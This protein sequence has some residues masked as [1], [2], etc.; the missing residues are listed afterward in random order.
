MDDPVRYQTIS[1][2][3]R[4]QCQLHGW[5]R[6]ISD[7]IRWYQMTVSIAWMTPSDVWMSNSFTSP[8]PDPLFTATLS[9]QT[10]A[11]LMLIDWLMIDWLIIDCLCSW[12]PVDVVETARRAEAS[13][14]GRVKVFRTRGNP[15][16]RQ[17]FTILEDCICSKIIQRENLQPSQ[18]QC[19]GAIHREAILGPE[20]HT[21][22]WNLIDLKIIFIVH[23]QKL[24]HGAL[25]QF[26]KG[27]VSR[28]KHSEG[29][30][31]VGAVGEGDGDGGEQ[32]GEAVVRGEHLP[33]GGQPCGRGERSR[34]RGRAWRERACNTSFM[35]NTSSTRCNTSSWGATFLQ[36][37]KLLL[38]AIS[39]RDVFV[40]RDGSFP[41]WKSCGHLSFG[42][43]E[44]GPFGER[45]PNT[46]MLQEATF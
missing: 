17:L 36:G 9:L 37:A 30:L 40:Q 34:A 21:W 35:C 31:E 5:P 8:V 39:R 15:H 4:W 16:L 3:I 38:G 6:P 22:S 44:D 41:A 26:C 24:V 10:I 14:S 43:T 29:W 42:F 25:G 19:G 2:D 11:M 32:G 23:L 7:D 45:D 1:D 12:K 46:T 13:P 28:G 27:R 20:K 18:Q 33:G